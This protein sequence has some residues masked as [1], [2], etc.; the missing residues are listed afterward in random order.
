M[1]RR[2]VEGPIHRSVLHWLRLVLPG[3]LIHHAANE[4]D[5]S[6]DRVMRE[7]GKAKALGM[8]KGWPDIEVLTADGPLFLEVKAP[9]RGPSKDQASIHAE[10]RRLGYRVAVVRS[11]E[12]A[13]AALAEWG[14]VTREAR[15]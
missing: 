4:I 7:I 1:A 2:D 14:V 13:R 5:M 15:A 10:M 9:G 6:G 11:I 8:V 3:A 12:D